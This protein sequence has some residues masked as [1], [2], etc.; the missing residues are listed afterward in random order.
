MIITER[1]ALMVNKTG[2]SPHWCLFTIQYQLTLKNLHP[3]PIYF[4]NDF[5]I[6][7]WL[8]E[9]LNNKKG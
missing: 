6:L 8:L 7:E 5:V 3:L 2:C 9:L 4:T 1:R